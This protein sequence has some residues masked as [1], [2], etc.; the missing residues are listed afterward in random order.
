[1]VIGSYGSYIYGWPSKYQL[2]FWPVTDSPSVYCCRNCKLSLFLWDFDEFPKEKFEEA[3]KILKDIKL[4]FENGKYSQ[5]A[6]TTR[7]EIAEKIYGLL[8]KKQEFWC[9]FHRILGYHHSAEGDQDKASKSRKKA[10]EIATEM[11]AKKDDS[12]DLKTQILISGAMKHFLKED[13]GAEADFKKALAT[14]FEDKEAS[15]EEAASAEKNIN[16]FIEEYLTAIKSDKP[17][18]GEDQ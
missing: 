17:P 18:R 14:K 16:S 3:R 12:L 9:R 5:V 4:T 10:L 2:I 8:D 7:L 1:M 6:M 11:I 13:L 15:A